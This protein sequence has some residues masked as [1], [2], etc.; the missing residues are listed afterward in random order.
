MRKEF[1]ITGLFYERAGYKLR[2]YLDIKKR[3]SKRVKPDLMVVMMNPGSSKPLNGI[4]NSLVPAEAVPDNTQDQIIKVMNNLSFEYARV[5]NLS[6]LRTPQSNELFN[7]LKSA[8]SLK[9]DHSIFS[10]SRKNELKK[11]FIKDV[12]VIYAW[13]VD[14]KLSKLAKKAIASLSVEK[15]LGM[16]KENSDFAFYHPLPRIYKDQIKWVEYISKQAS[17]PR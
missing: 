1:N 5:L 3:G 12:P 17:K 6:D 10:D 7:F 9:V 4:D 2:K 14:R 11:L 13:G 8:D 15:P 16:V